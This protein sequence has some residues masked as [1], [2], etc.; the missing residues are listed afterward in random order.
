MKFAQ[1]NLIATTELLTLEV[2]QT[3]Q[4]FVARE[5]T[6]RFKAE[7]LAE[8]AL[9]VVGVIAII[10][11]YLQWF[12]P[13]H[14]GG[15][16]Q[17]VTIRTMLTVAFVGSGLGLF[18]FATRGFQ[19]WVSLDLAERRVAVGRLNRKNRT[20][21]RRKFRFQDIESLVVQRNR[22]TRNAALCMRVKGRPAPLI[23]LTGSTEE[24]EALHRDISE[25]IQHAS[26]CAP[27][28]VR[29][30]SRAKNGPASD[31]SIANSGTDIRSRAMP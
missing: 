5:A 22:D 24:L 29:L 21:T 2:S 11:G 17:T 3:P 14:F 23:C 16:G 8:D 19:R 6:A 31:R 15:I 28:R 9:R 13:E 1:S 7:R 10:A 4:D 27:K 30:H 26:S 12:L 25:I 18:L 20:I